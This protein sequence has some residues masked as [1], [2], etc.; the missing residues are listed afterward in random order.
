VEFK[1]LKIGVIALGWLGEKLANKLTKNGADVWGTTQ[2][3]EKQT[4]IK[5][6]SKIDC[7]IWRNDEGISEKLKEKLKQ[8]DILILNLPPSVFQNEN[9]SEGLA[10][11]LPFLNDMAKVIFTS[12]SSVY[13]SHLSNAVESY[14]FKANEINKIRE[15]EIKLES[16]LGNRLTILRLAG[17]I[18]EDRHPVYYLAKKIS[19]DEADKPINLIQR[20][21]VIETI[22]KVITSDYFGEMLNVCHPEHPPKE[23]YYSSKAKQFNLPE[24]NFIKS[25]LNENHKVVNCEKLINNL[26]YKTFEPI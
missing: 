9:Y 5:E 1:N 24:L 20:S 10:Q 7:L 13:P 11:F 22:S 15:A 16:S 14:N 12:S 26:G 6:H 2:L 18:G 4:R 25:I 8:T 21:D 19:N 23:V 17:L 3:P